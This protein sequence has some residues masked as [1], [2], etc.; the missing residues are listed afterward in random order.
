LEEIAAQTRIKRTYLEALEE[1]RFDVFPGEAYLTG[2]LRVYASMLGLEVK[3]VLLRYREQ[4]S[5]EQS[6]KEEL[7][8]SPVSPSVPLLPHAKR[9]KI[10]FTG[11]FLAVAAVTAAVFLI[12][13]GHGPDANSEFL[14]AEVTVGQQEESSAVS[15]RKMVSEEKPGNGPDAVAEKE[16]ESSAVA[17]LPSDVPKVSGKP[18]PSIPPSGAIIRLEAL[19]PGR[20]EISVDDRHPQ[21]YQLQAEIVLSWKVRHS[22]R[23]CVESPDAVRLWLG[24]EQLHFD[25]KNELVLGPSE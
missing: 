19:G 1:D 18:L 8:F 24:E 22:V 23:I 14:S 15:D 5:P 16:A 6:E 17:V 20:L 21:L 2:F 4:V 7:T 3:K 9:A 11:S 13:R 25:F 10:W 12:L